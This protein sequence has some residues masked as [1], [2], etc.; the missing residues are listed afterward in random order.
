M[1]PTPLTALEQAVGQLITGTILT[2]W[3]VLA[4]LGVRK[5]VQLHR[6][7]IAVV[8]RATATSPAAIPAQRRS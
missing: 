1:D 2:A 5:L 3:L 8:R 4:A 7:R 6:R